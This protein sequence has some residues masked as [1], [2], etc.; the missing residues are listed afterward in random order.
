MFYFA[1]TSLAD[2]VGLTINWN[3]I[4]RHSSCALTE[5]KASR[6]FLANQN[7]TRRNSNEPIKWT[8]QLLILVTVF[9]LNDRGIWL[10]RQKRAK[11]ARLFYSWLVKTVARGFCWPIKHKPYSFYL[12]WITK[13]LS[14]LALT[15]SRL[16]Y[17]LCQFSSM[18]LVF[19]WAGMRTS[20]SKTSS[21]KTWEN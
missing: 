5:A 6:N 15:S 18:L 19:S 20:S 4:C 12:K 7:V 2:Y 1:F 16:W 8:K 9:L 10:T 14:S 21:L 3:R 11:R 13:P 17:V